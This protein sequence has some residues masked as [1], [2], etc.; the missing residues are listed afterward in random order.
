MPHNSGVNDSRYLLRWVVWIG[1]LANWSFAA[2]AFV[3]PGKLV[4]T[5]GLGPFGGT[6]WLFNYSVLLVILGC[7][8]IPAARDPIR[9]QTS[10][11]LM[12]AARL[13]P[14][15]TFFVGV[16]VG[17]MPTGLLRLGAGDAAFGTAIWILLTLVRR[18][19]G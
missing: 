3:D 5:L 10:A 18:H 11:W 13:V 1:I 4:E 14:A 15:T 16:F 17:F 2:W 8:Y 7:F 9:Y 12:I 19:D 6:I